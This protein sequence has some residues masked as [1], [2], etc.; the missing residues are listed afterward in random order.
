MS[1][2]SGGGG[3]RRLLAGQG[4]EKGWRHCRLYLPPDMKKDDESHRDFGAVA[5]ERCLAAAAEFHTSATPNEN[6][7]KGPRLGAPTVNVPLAS[8]QGIPVGAESI[9]PLYLRFLV[10]MSEP[11]KHRRT[12]AAMQLE[13][14]KKNNKKNILI[15]LTPT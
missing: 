6:Q 15:L 9:S 14:N 7:I 5:C 13:R 11:S 3:P 1:L 2:S 8:V 10:L 4:L 12:T